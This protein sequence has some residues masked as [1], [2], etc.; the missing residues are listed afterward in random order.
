MLTGAADTGNL[1]A[2]AVA[3]AI[4]ARYG[5]S[6]AA[7]FGISPE[8]F[9]EIVSAVIARYAVGADQA[10]QTELVASLHIVEL[11]LARA[12]A[13]GNDAAWEVFL[14]RFRAMLY[15]AAYRICRNDSAGR[16]LADELYSDLYGLPNQSGRRVC[17]FDYY[18]GRGSME[19]WLRAVLS[20]QHINRIRSRSREVSLDEQLDAGIGFAAP[21]TDGLA[22]AQPGDALAAAVQSSLA[23]LAAEE[24]FLLASWYLD[25]R[26]L[27]DIARQLRVHESTIS[28]R[29]DRI[30]GA[31]HK[32]I[33]KRLQA[34]G[35]SSRQ[36]DER[37][38]ELDVRDLEIDVNATLRQESPL[39]SFQK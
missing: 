20:Q 28:R 15:E 36:C 21:A 10:E 18:M 33:R 25:R 27:A 17:R 32:R 38:N 2:T 5:E 29:L 6:N 39:E 30:T 34:G 4:A 12:C 24:R 19:G 23:E 31:L 3:A 11:V 8:A 14:T 1:P 35:L 7:R 37:I 16:E 9:H 22:A 13:A 26:T